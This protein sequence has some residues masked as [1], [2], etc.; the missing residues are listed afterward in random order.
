MATFSVNLNSEGRGKG[1]AS[2]FNKK[3]RHVKNI[4]N[5]GYTLSKVSSEKF[6]VFGIYRSKD[7]DVRQMIGQLEEM[8]KENRTTVIGGDLNVCALKHHKNLI[9]E[10]LKELKFQQIVKQAT[11][12]E[13][14]LIDHL[15]IK[16]GDDTG[17]T[18]DLEIVPKYF[19]DHDCV[20]L[21]VWEEELN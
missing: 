6:D 12:I 15:Y 5:T 1:I 18:W 2:Y 4:K 3:F 19:T 7:G 17:V 13:G 8:I 14:G 9:T 16:Q 20:R 11:H 10:K 21:A